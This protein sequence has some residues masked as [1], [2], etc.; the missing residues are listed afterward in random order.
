MATVSPTAPPNV[1]AP[2][3]PASHV[4]RARR[5]ASTRQH[6]RGGS[7]GATG[8]AAVVVSPHS[9]ASLQQ[10]QRSPT[11]RQ[12]HHHHHY[13][14]RYN[15]NH[16]HQTPAG[17][18]SPTQPQQQRQ[19]N[20]NSSGHHRYDYHRSPP[21]YADLTLTPASTTGSPYVSGGIV[22][23][24]FSPLSS[25]PFPLRRQLPP[26]HGRYRS[27]LPVPPPLRS[28]PT[29]TAPTSMTM[30]TTI[31][32]NNNVSREDDEDE[33]DA[34][35]QQQQQQQQRN[36]EPSRRRG[37]P[38]PLSVSAHTYHQQQQHSSSGSGGSPNIG[39]HHGYTQ[40]SVRQGMYHR[41]TN[42]KA[43]EVEVEETNNGLTTPVDQR[44]PAMVPPSYDA[45][46]LK[47]PAHGAAA[48]YRGTRYENNL[49]NNR[50]MAAAAAPA[51]GT[52]ATAAMEATFARYPSKAAFTLKALQPQVACTQVRARTTRH[53]TAVLPGEPDSSSAF[54][55]VSETPAV[56]QERVRVA[57]AT[58]ADDAMAAG[59]VAPADPQR[60]RSPARA[61]SA[62]TTTMS[63]SAVNPPRQVGCGVGAKEEEEEKEEN[64][65]TPCRAAFGSRCGSYYGSYDDGDNP[66]RHHHHQQQQ[67]QRTGGVS[68]AVS[69]WRSPSSIARGGRGEGVGMG[70]AWLKISSS[71]DASAF[72]SSGGSN[73][74]FGHPGPLTTSVVAFHS[75]SSVTPFTTPARATMKTTNTTIATTA[76]A[77]AQQLR[78]ASVEEESLL[79]SGQCCSTPRALCPPLP[80]FP[81]A[82]AFPSASGAAADGAP[83]GRAATHGMAG[84]IASDAPPGGR[85]PLPPPP[86]SPV[87]TVAL[88]WGAAVPQQAER[89]NAPTSTTASTAATAA[90][91][92]TTTHTNTTSTST[93][94]MGGAVPSVLLSPP[95]A[96]TTIDTDHPTARLRYLR[97]A[98]FLISV[99]EEEEE[100][101]EDGGR[102]GVAA[103]AAAAASDVSASSVYCSPQ[104]LRGHERLRLSLEG[105]IGRSAMAT[106]VDVCAPPQ[107]VHR[108]LTYDL[109]SSNYDVPATMTPSSTN[110][111]W[112]T[113]I[114]TSSLQTPDAT[115]V[116]TSATTTAYG[117]DGWCSPM[118]WNPRQARDD[119]E[120]FAAKEAAQFAVAQ[121]R[122]TTAAVPSISCTS[123]SL[124]DTNSSNGDI[125]HVVVLQRTGL[126]EPSLG[127]LSAASHVARVA[128][129]VGASSSSSCVLPACVAHRSP[130]NGRWAV[131]ARDGEKYS[132][133]PSRFSYPPLQQDEHQQQ[134]QREAREEAEAE[135]IELLL[136]YRDRENEGSRIRHALEDAMGSPPLAATTPAAAAAAA[137]PITPPS[138]A[139]TPTTTTAT[140]A[141]DTATPLLTSAGE[142]DGARGSAAAA[143]TLA[144][145]ATSSI[146][147][148]GF[149]SSSRYPYTQQQQQQS[150]A[151]FLSSSSPPPA[152][153][154]AAMSAPAAGRTVALQVRRQLRLQREASRMHKWA[155]LAA[156]LPMYPPRREESLR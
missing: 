32:S 41:T 125:G 117:F 30:T 88:S 3:T 126:R 49:S 34:Q 48:A 130:E 6:T 40:R 52:T 38:P 9:S 50:M 71:I 135:W 89:V 19:L 128:G 124:L 81:V 7:H 96:T 110:N 58:P 114:F 54:R 120:M 148:N 133:A 62:V 33:E 97:D 101:E 141:A 74:G 45:Y 146:M 152:P 115:T 1:E 53:K 70:G 11:Q 61:R 94:M 36:A 37:L 105:S 106:P 60:G 103:A 23:P 26:T 142:Q 56:H 139:A 12:H 122:R 102:G 149:S 59:Y 92:A 42:Q 29:P 156:R 18:R 8:A 104:Q 75:T 112:P 22:T 132:A 27:S 150:A 44:I 144:W 80:S 13:N 55:R 140:A 108:G 143:A 145:W 83:T 138:A 39:T 155:Y 68:P 64:D 4:S 46:N 65:A 93:T 67:H 121:H 111:N 100:C 113:A 72:D 76:A 134:Q 31:T 16:H 66:R 63:S 118:Q 129:A 17:Q 20:G 99:G 154:C 119:I 123:P 107:R 25:P 90:A 73:D 136:H 91:A 5:Q 87:P 10:Q 82:A 43:A 85:R 35:Q 147:R 79:L 131:H 2:R 153:L 98:N 69:E 15:H 51:A 116:T 47:S 77:A 84:P 21:A 95:F 14:S 109:G 151:V 127:H 57:A 86:R 24:S 78:L 137:E 28:L